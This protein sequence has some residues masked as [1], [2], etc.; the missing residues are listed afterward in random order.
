M[1]RRHRHELFL[2]QLYREFVS[3][4][5]ERRCSAVGLREKDSAGLNVV[6]DLVQLRIRELVRLAAGDLEDRRIN[7]FRPRRGDVDDLPVEFLF[8]Q[9]ADVAGEVRRMRGRLAQ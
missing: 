2:E 9:L 6:A 8:L 7:P 4:L 1:I 3:V 5:V